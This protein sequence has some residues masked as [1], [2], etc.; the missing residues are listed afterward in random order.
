[1]YVVIRN[2]KVS[3]EISKIVIADFSAPSAVN[4]AEG[5][6]R[7]DVLVNTKADDVDEVKILYYWKDKDSVEK[8]HASKEHQAMHIEQHKRRKEEGVDPIKRKDL[9][10]TFDEFELV[11]TLNAK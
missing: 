8:W 11:S 3:K 9:N 7:R 6:I 5:F 4:K 1:M 10:M 2:M